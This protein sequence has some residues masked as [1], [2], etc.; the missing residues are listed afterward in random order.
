VTVRTRLGR[1]PLLLALAATLSL[2]AVAAG[3]LV[4]TPRG[5]T[6]RATAT[7]TGLPP[8]LDAADL[9]TLSVRV[10]PSPG[11][12]TADVTVR[13]DGKR[14]AARRDGRHLVLEPR[15]LGDGRHELTVEV[16]GG[17][18]S[19]STSRHAFTVDTTPPVLTLPE[20]LNAAGLRDEVTVSG[21][22]EGADR[23][24]VN[25]VPAPVVHGRFEARLP[26]PPASVEVVATDAAGNTARSEVPVHVTHPPM[27]GVHMTAL[28]WTASSLRG[29]I[30]DMARE[31]RI[32]TV[33]LD[34]KD[35]DGLVGYDSRVRLA[36]R[37]GAVR[38]YYDAAA[39]IR[40]LHA[41]DVRVVGRIVAFRDPRLGRWAWK[42]G[43]RGWVIQTPG[44]GPYGGKY[45]AYSFTNPFSADVREYN[46]ALATEAARLGFDDV[47]YDYVRRP[48]GALRGLR[49]PG[50]E[51]SPE[52]AIA[53]FMRETRE[54]VRAE[55]AFLGA[56]VYGIA[57]TRPTEIAQDIPTMAESADYI[58]PMVYPSHW[59]PG[60]YGV[61]NP[62]RS[63]YPIVRRSLADF[64]RLVRGSDTQI[65][66][67]LQDFSLG[68]TYGPAQVR[69]QIRAAEDAGID[70]F[71]LWNAA[72]RYTRA[73][74][75]PAS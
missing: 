1:R 18:R 50:R 54:A 70:S 51:G 47:L 3:V 35:E 74:L 58:A 5:A 17:G 30:L 16:E 14:R 45:G 71:L 57:A 64:Q 22:A 21:T 10:T 53:G 9:A 69:A 75:P 24:K 48:D 31:G 20:R 65:M 61:A 36:R 28:A 62:N 7:V 15:G 44:G 12:R 40:K 60:E 27:R 19:G 72:A 34:I 38:G 37:I 6:G 67:W 73:A 55:G 4:V 29:P 49:F 39:A 8:T 52:E 33:E 42:H 66:P 68:V 59:G 56:S 41:M 63:P 46:I 25:D 32:D 23:V 2:A 13:L 26:T 11:S 43:R